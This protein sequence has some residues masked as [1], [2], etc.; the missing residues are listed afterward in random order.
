MSPFRPSPVV[1]AALAIAAIATFIALAPA[2]AATQNGLGYFEATGDIGPPAIAGSTVYDAGMQVYTL[3][4]AGTNMWA[5]KDEFH[6]A[7]RKLTGNFILRAQVKFLGQGVEAHRKLGWIVRSSLAPDATYAD[8]AVHGNGLTSL[9]YRSVKGGPTFQLPSMVSAPDVV[10]LERTGKTFIMSVAKYGQPFTRT[11]LNELDLG[12]DVYVGL[13]VCAH[14]PGVSERGV[15]S[16][17]RIVVPPPAGWQPYRDYIGSNLEVMKIGSHAL[18]VLY[19]A[20][21]SF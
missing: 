3:T 1:R 10:Q 2:P 12:D 17:V 13:F 4:G 21:G 16:N 9:Q 11:D 18:K 7:Y 19:T 15:F 5:T 6:F 20:P 14:N 8:A